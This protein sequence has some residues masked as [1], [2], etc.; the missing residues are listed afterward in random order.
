MMIKT[1]IYKSTFRRV[2]TNASTIPKKKAHCK[3]FE[4]AQVIEPAQPPQV[5][6]IDP[7]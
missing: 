1:K 3:D 7:P 5:P 4:S 6:K 2:I